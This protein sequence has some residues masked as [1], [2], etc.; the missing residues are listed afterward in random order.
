MK[1][2]IAKWTTAVAAAAVI[3]MPATGLAQTPTP[4]PQPPTTTEPG[5]TMTQPAPQENANQEAAK[6]HL[7]AARNTLSELTQL[8]AAAQLTGEARTHVAQLISNFN[9]MITTDMQWRAAYAKLEANLDALLGPRAAGEPANPPTT[10]PSGTPGAVG[11][12]GITDLDPE[13][14]AKLTQF[15]EHLERF[16]Q[17]ASG[18]QAMTDPA[19]PQTH[20]TEGQTTPPAHPH[21]AAGHQAQGD[22]EELLRHIDAIEAILGIQSAASNARGTAGAPSQDPRSTTSSAPTGTTTGTTPPSTTP[23]AV[24]TTGTTPSVLTLD[25]AQLDQLRLHLNELRRLA[26][27]R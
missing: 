5:Q 11:T 14:R 16:E 25:E 19:H 22:R 27:Q 26:N 6:Q 17:V 21:D 24:G 1:R 23:G 18:G 4:P 12:S 2:S 10:P 7:T 9:E 8:P 3:A 15:R 20:T 13:V